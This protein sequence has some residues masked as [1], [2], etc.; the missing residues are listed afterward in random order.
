MK[1]AVLILSLICLNSC[2]FLNL[3]ANQEIKTKN[4]CTKMDFS[5]NLPIIEVEIDKK[6]KKFLFDTGA[7]GT[8]ILDSSII[9]D[10]ENKN[11]YSFGSIKDASGKK[12][13]NRLYKVSLYSNLFE[14]ENK[15]MSFVNMP[16]SKCAKSKKSYVGI[17]GLSVFFENSLSLQMDFTNNDIC[18]ISS[19]QLNKLIQN[20]DYELIKSKTH[21]D[22][23]FIF[24]KVEG[25]EY[26]FK[27][28][29]GFS[30][31]I[32]MP[33]NKKLNFNNPNKRELAGSLYQTVSAQTFGKEVNYEK[34]PVSFGSHS[35]SSKLNVSTSIKSQNVG[36]EFIK[37]FDWIID[38][39]NNKVYI[40]KNKNNIVNEFSKKINFLAK[41]IDKE[42]KIMVK[43]KSQREYNIGDIITHV[44]KIKI[45][46]DNICEM[47]D[48]L[49]KTE[50]WSSL[51][52]EVTST[53]N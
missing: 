20:E 45:T 15:M 39:K 1:K 41:I 13:T 36:I 18:N 24:L 6:T 22:K 19:E 43:E 42:L 26:K 4:D 27:L 52:L 8:A 11:F 50:D 29:T 21:S 44:N 40:K 9:D 47:Q 46:S 48:L 17:I 23:I 10:F 12:I 3:V 49:N 35:F 30:G 34:M 5:N 2:T 38:V 37:G 53:K 25:K 16:K 33:Y 28:D 7:T 51:N 14:S 32:I 31:N